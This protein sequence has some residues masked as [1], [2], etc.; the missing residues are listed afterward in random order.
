MM[1]Y[2]VHLNIHFI[3]L[4]YHV[5]SGE[6]SFSLSAGIRRTQ[7]VN[8]TE[9]F[10]LNHNGESMIS[11]YSDYLKRIASVTEEELKADNSNS[12]ESLLSSVDFAKSWTPVKKKQKTI[13]TLDGFGVLI[14]TKAHEALCKLVT[15]EKS[16]RSVVVDKEQPE[17]IP[18]IKLAFY[19]SRLP[20][21]DLNIMFY[22][23]GDSSFAIH[24]LASFRYFQAFQHHLAPMKYK[25]ISA[26]AFEADVILRKNIFR[27]EDDEYYKLDFGKTC[28]ICVRTGD[29]FFSDSAGLPR[30]TEMLSVFPLDEISKPL[31]SNTCCPTDVVVVGASLHPVCYLKL[32]FDCLNGS[33]VRFIASSRII[34]NVFNLNTSDALLWEKKP[35]LIASQWK[36]MFMSR[37]S[38]IRERYDENLQLKL[39]ELRSLRTPSFKHH[40]RKRIYEA[41]DRAVELHF[42]D[43]QGTGDANTSATY[44]SYQNLLTMVYA[45]VHNVES[46]NNEHIYAVSSK[47]FVDFEQKKVKFV[48]LIGLSRRAPLTLTTFDLLKEYVKPGIVPSG[49]LDK[50]TAVITD[51][52]N[53]LTSKLVHAV[54]RH[55]Y[56]CSGSLPNW[57]QSLDLV[58]DTGPTWTPKKVRFICD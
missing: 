21:T 26:M 24:T 16:F 39:F 17:Y 3:F 27:C 28:S 13:D 8:R 54:K 15:D 45:W 55:Y 2:T 5:L 44:I 25:A 58:P 31:S 33:V 49:E 43:N 46:V 57:D 37:E 30:H 52:A 51:T 36:L 6:Q 47:Y 9:W 22:D 50:V 29:E 32:L 41:F 7:E 56:G 1:V 48:D 10:Y 23:S 11:T 18:A 20:T 35:F 14:H 34:D 42:A 38:G 40:L 19:W 4:Y 53:F 12:T